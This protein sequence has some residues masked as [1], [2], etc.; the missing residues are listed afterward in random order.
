MDIKFLL[1]PSLEELILEWWYTADACQSGPIL[2][3]DL[4]RKIEEWLPREQT[5]SGSQLRPEQECEIDG[6]NQAIR[7]IKQRARGKR[8]EVY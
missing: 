6:Y 1:Q 7:L 3:N 8:V 2:A 5:Y 4:A